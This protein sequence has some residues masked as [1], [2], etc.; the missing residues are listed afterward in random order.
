MKH[1]SFIV[2]LCALGCFGQVG[3]ASG[4]AVDGLTSEMLVDPVCLDCS[5]PRL[6]WRLADQQCG[7]RQTACQILVGS[8]ADMLAHGKGDLW[9]SGEVQSD[10]SV[11]VSYAGRPL[12]S[13][14]TVFWKVRIKDQKGE[15]SPWSSTASWRMGL[16]DSTDWGTAQWIRIKNDTRTSALMRRPFVRE[17]GAAVDRKTLPSPVLRKEFQI[18]KPVKQAMA[19]VCGLGYFEL[20]VNGGKTGD[21]VL[22]PVQTTYDKRVCYVGFDITRQL[23]SG[24][25]AVGLMLGNGF[26]GQDFAFG[27]GLVYGPPVAIGLLAVEYTDGTTETITTGPD[28]KAAMGPVVFDNVYVGETYDARLEI[29]GWNRP[30]FDDRAWQSAATVAAPTKKLIAQ[31]VPPIKKIRTVVPVGILPGTNGTWIVDMGQNMTGWLRIRVQGESGRQIHMRFGEVLMP[32]G[33]EIDTATTGTHVTGGDQTDIYVCKG[34]GVEEWEPR[35]T[36]HGFRYVQIDGLGQKPQLSD[37]TGWLVRTA[38][39]RIGHFQ[40]S[41][42]RINTFYNVSMWTIE[43]NLQGI[44]TDCPHRERCAWMGDMH[45]VGEAASYNFDLMRFWRKSSADME[46]VLGAAAPRK[47]GGLPSDPRAPCNIAVGKRLCQQARPDWGVATVLVPW[48]NWLYFGDFE[49]VET[50][51]PMMAGWMD[52]LAEFAVKDG[53]IEEGYGDWCPPG[54]NSEIDTP[55]ALTSTAFY[56]QSL[57]AMRR[58]AAAL[59]KSADAARYAAQATVVKQAFIARF[60]DSQQHHFGSQ[61]GPAVALHSGLAPD[62]QE[63]AVADGLAWLVME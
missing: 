49:T 56:Y 26:F 54:S 31:M 12:H 18:G 21:H 20:Y 2:L 7:A 32:D 27:T 42:E 40:C 41:D 15:W 29:P 63:Q 6:S 57:E 39:E 47:E 43:D 11:F 50:A 8:S 52:F 35:F 36:Y 37:F 38:A 45:A 59:G 4:A 10:Q 3:Y 16:L 5:A 44:L 62:G 1:P 22:D 55:V 48:F 33:N 9:D 25:N 14:Q 13:R 53:I 61:T 34:G 46:T 19:Y 17:N 51:W 60:Y 24:G 23:Q 58:M 28:W 30:G